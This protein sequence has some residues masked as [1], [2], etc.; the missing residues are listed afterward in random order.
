VYKFQHKN[1]LKNTLLKF[2]A[3]LQK[4]L[5]II[6]MVF[7]IS[8]YAAHTIG[9]DS[10]ENKRYIDNSDIEYTMTHI[11]ISRW[12]HPA[13]LHTYHPLFSLSRALPATLIPRRKSSLSPW[14]AIRSALQI[15]GRTNI[16]LNI[17][18]FSARL[19]DYIVRFIT[20][21]NT[22]IFILTRVTRKYSLCLIKR[23]DKFFEIS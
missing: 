14:A 12:I 10:F 16:S 20:H 13:L 19:E 9:K 21:T 18:L 3:V 2:D 15:A 4:T 8:R 7:E 22:Y 5:C 17:F 11:P 23:K 6:K 1:S